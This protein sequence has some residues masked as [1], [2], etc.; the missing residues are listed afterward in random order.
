MTQT[1]IQARIAAGF[2]ADASREKRTQ[3]EQ[4]KVAMP[5]RGE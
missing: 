2:A 5:T 1:A 3:R 4:Y